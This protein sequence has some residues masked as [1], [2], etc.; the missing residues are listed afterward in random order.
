MNQA[1]TLGQVD[2]PKEE[3][4]RTNRANIATERKS[5]ADNRRK[6]M[7][8]EKS[9][10]DKQQFKPEQFSGS[11]G[12]Y[13][14]FV[15]KPSDVAYEFFTQLA[16]SA[17]TNTLPP[18]EYPAA[19]GSTAATAAPGS[20]TSG[21]AN[22]AQG[23]LG[24]AS[25]RVLTDSTGAI[26][27]YNLWSIR[28]KKVVY[29]GG[30]WVEFS[31]DDDGKIATL[32]K[33]NGSFLKRDTAPD[34][35][36]TAT[37]TDNGS[38]T[39]KAAIVVMADGSFQITREDRT[40]ETYTTAGKKIVS[41]AFPEKFDFR[42]SL[43]R[44]F[45][46]LDRDKKGY[47]SKDDV[48]RAVIT[49]WGNQDDAQL[50]AMLKWHF[51]HIV[52]SRSNFIFKIG[53]GITLDEITEYDT[54]K[55]MGDQEVREPS[56]GVIKSLD[57]LFSLIDSNRDGVVSLDEMKALA[58]TAALTAKQKAALG[59]FLTNT[60]RMHS[61]GNR[62][63]ID[64]TTM[65]TRADFMK[66]YK[67]IYKD[68]VGRYIAIGGWGIE[69]RWQ[70]ASQA[71]RNL[72]A[73]ATNPL[74]S[75]QLEAIKQGKVGDCVFLSALAS[76]IVVRPQLI[77]DI[78]KDNGNGTFTVTFP[79]A[80]DEPVI[81][82]APTTSEL[83]V[84]ARGSEFGIWA[85]I[86]EKA[87]GFYIGRTNKS[88]AIIATEN[89][90]RAEENLKCFK[91]LT[92]RQGRWEFTKDFFNIGF[93]MCRRSVSDADCRALLENCFREKRALVA[94]AF[95]GAD[96][97]GGTP[98]I[99]PGHAYSIIGW[100]RNTD[101]VE[102]RNP[103]GIIPRDRSTRADIMFLQTGRRIVDEG[104]NGIFRLPMTKFYNSFDCIY[105]ENAAPEQRA[106]LTAQTL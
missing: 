90:N 26:I 14:F 93:G 98:V 17:S 65:M 38:K 34:A 12:E 105:I 97:E 28:P 91:I 84:F 45:K 96:A 100:D 79:G 10:A 99:V 88:S 57:E 64:R 25:E 47:L 15:H 53:R 85:P 51:E 56:P 19:H 1:I 6:I 74:K 27:T 75:I 106:T 89:S 49:E 50:A 20:Y 77:V 55:Q 5:E 23:T 9:D 2:V 76:L 95:T 82:E 48:D 43:G 18:G 16:H 40:V 4:K 21:G 68:E 33:S 39:D 59:N 67:E 78:I 37:W 3:K 66:L 36:N 70:S 62:G 104:T 58:Q 7:T 72:Y 22:V 94:G 32:T 73:D 35:T 87:Y 86:L 54:K 46:K 102:V 92:G 83:A 30:D 103:W 24:G 11:L 29:T 52:I 31:Y 42:Q 81:Q 80:P 63:L 41:K 44:I 8:N 61:F 101:E 60:E 13:K 71:N 69:E